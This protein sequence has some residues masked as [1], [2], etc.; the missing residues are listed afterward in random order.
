MQG[1]YHPEYKG[2]PKNPTHPKVKQAATIMLSYPLGVE[3]N[4]TVLANDLSFYDGIT[5]PD[6]PAMTWAM[7]AIGW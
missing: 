7:F 1:G 6:G 2:F 5:D 3:M 4:Q